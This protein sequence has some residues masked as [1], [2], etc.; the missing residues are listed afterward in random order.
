MSDT[1]RDQGTRDET[2][3]TPQPEPAPTPR[4][5]P[6]F[7]SLKWRAGNA[8]VNIFAKVGIGPMHLLTTKGRTTGRP[9]TVPVVPVT[10]DGHEWLVAPYGPVSWVHNVRSDGAVTLRHGRTTQRFMTREASGEE[11]G[12]VLKR[13]LAVATKTREWFHA[14]KDSPV[15]DFVAE[16]DEH[17]VFE[18][19]PR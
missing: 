18:L 2:A 15:D 17:P 19:I 3:T 14:G 7:K 1:A 8:L 6:A 16:A 5:T 4:P 10:H 13:Y 11:A 9:H 12:P